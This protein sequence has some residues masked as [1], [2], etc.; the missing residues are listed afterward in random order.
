[1]ATNISYIPGTDASCLTLAEAKKQLRVDA[2][3]TEEDDLIQ[4]Y[5]ESAQVECENFI[6]R[7]I[8]RRKMVVELAAFENPFLFSANYEN[9]T[10][11]KVEYY[12]KATNTIQTLDPV[13]YKLRVS[14]VVNC[15]EIKFLNTLPETALRDDAVII[16]IQ[17]GFAVAS[18]PAPIK[19]AMK[20]LISDSYERREDR[21]EVGYNTAAHAKLRPY[22]KY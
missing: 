5:I 18:V 14:S 6:N 2:S 13:E 17:Q 9:D 3:F 11:E 20:L 12:D 4:S 19:A 15:K 7:A 22:R 10:V 8:G 1:M 21:A 16:T